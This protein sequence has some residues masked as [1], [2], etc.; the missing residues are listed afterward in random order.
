MRD[1]KKYGKFAIVTGA[2]SGIGA[3]FARQI[4][5]KGVGVVLVA[6]RVEKL[7][8]L[9]GELRTVHNAD[10]V[11]LPLDLTAP[12]A[13]AELVER[14]AGLD[15]GMIVASAGV[16]TA[17]AFLEQ[18]L[19]AELE[20]IGLNLSVP[21]QLAHAFG[22][23]FMK[24]GRGALVL[25]SS[26]VAFAPVPFTANYAAVKAYVASFGQ[27]LAFELRRTGVDVLTVAPGPTRTEGVETTE[28]IDFGKLPLPM[29]SPERVVRTSLRALGRKA[30]VIPGG[31]NQ[32]SDALG[33]YTTPRRVQ[34]AMFGRLVNR[35]LTAK[36]G[37]F[38]A[39]RPR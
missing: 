34:T 20:L 3:E 31:I 18:E 21:V 17:G 24:R 22:L 30:L 1:L 15:V 27:A 35:A 33:K 16:V 26:S 9:A 13:V 37:E 7:E 25:L 12:G 32:F 39:A 28:G 38:T 5:A 4:A 6:R 2:S 29:M 8:A 10:V 19:T 14:T 23:R 11:L 36:P